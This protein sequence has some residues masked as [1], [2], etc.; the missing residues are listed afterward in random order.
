MLIGGSW[1]R[2]EVLHL[3]WQFFPDADG[4]VVTDQKITLNDEVIFQGGNHLGCGFND[5]ID[6]FRLWSF[7]SNSV[8]VTI[9]NVS[10][11]PVLPSGD[12][13]DDGVLDVTDINFLIYGIAQG[14]HSFDYDMNGDTKVDLLDRDLWLAVAGAAN[15]PAGNPYLLGDVN[16]DGS[17]DGTDYLAWNSNKFT[18]T[19]GWL[20]ADFNADG[21]TD[22]ADFLLWNQFKFAT[23]DVAAVPEPS[24]GFGLALLAIGLLRRKGQ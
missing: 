3:D 10:F 8:D 18:N 5:E 9:D 7:G 22:G 6:S 21:T 16:L 17:V 24:C 12:I 11:T 14:I 23:S 1:N 13:N 19:G 2:H 15:L 20:A 4:S